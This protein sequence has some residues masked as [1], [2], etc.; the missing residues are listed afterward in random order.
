MQPFPHSYTGMDP[1]NSQAVLD[2]YMNVVFYERGTL[3]PDV[4]QEE[5]DDKASTYTLTN[6][7]PLVPD[8]NNEVW[9]A[10]EQID[11]SRAP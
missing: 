4:H 9:T 1:G 8:F 7:V 3:N 2:D 10:Q 11:H 6:T 5:Q